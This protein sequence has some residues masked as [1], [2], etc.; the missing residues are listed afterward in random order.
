MLHGGVSQERDTPSCVR[1]LTARTAPYLA[2]MTSAS[3]G[4]EPSP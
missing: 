2:P 1:L 4:R 3:T